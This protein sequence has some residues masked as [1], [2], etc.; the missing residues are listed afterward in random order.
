VKADSAHKMLDVTN[1]RETSMGLPH[2]KSDGEMTD[3][4]QRLYTALSDV[5]AERA[6]K[7]PQGK[8]WYPLSQ[9]SYDVT[10]IAAVNDALLSTETTMGR[11]VQEFESGFA[12]VHD[13]GHAV[14]VN[15]GS[16]ADLLASLLLID[17]EQPPLQPGDEVLAPAVTWPTQ[18]DSLLMC[19]LSVR[20]VDA[21]PITLQMDLDDLEAKIGPRTRAISVVHLMGNP[22]NMTRLMDIAERHDLLVLE[23]C[24]E[25][26]GAAWKGKKVGTFGLA[27]A[28]SFFFSHHITTMEGGMVLTGSE[29]IGDKL[30]MLRA[31]GWT[32]YSTRGKTRELSVDERYTFS[33]WGVNVRPM[34]A[35]GAFGLVQ[36]GRLADFQQHRI[37]NAEAFQDL[38]A[39]LAD[40][41]SLMHVPEGATCSWFAL[42]LVVN[43]Q[44][45]VKRSEVTEALEA[46]GVETRPVVAGNLARQ[47]MTKLF[48]Q[49]VT[50]DLPGAE[51][52]HENGFYIGLHP[53]ADN[54]L[55][56]RLAKTLATVVS[57]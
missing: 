40:F 3:A 17:P 53:F 36:L 32:R 38:I 33:T 1:D 19:G 21:D 4:E 20:L 12:A 41:I 14:M 43:P 24:C 6:A 51:I 37:R 52:V 5:F 11:R 44:S 22:C 45:G 42:P 57:K 13:G 28:Y 48:P 35:Q 47:P 27:G 15:S 18:I 46:A 50:G 39:P 56:E 2:S 34:E 8:Y 7:Q 55:L 25:A 29:E 16:S 49:L 9:V 31:H 23:D 30:R 26:L 54:G 10:E